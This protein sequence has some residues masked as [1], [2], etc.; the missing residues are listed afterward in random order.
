MGAEPSGL[1]I[2]DTDDK[3][4]FRTLKFYHIDAP[5]YEA[6]VNTKNAKAFLHKA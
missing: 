5:N 6:D 4:S 2:I 1:V 3:F